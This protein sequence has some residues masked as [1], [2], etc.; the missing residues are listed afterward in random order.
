M[1]EVL[2]N[3]ELKISLPEGFREM[4]PDEMRQGFGDD[5]PD[6]LGVRDEERHIIFAVTWKVSNEAASKIASTKSL[7]E[8]AEKLIRKG[9]KKARIEYNCHGFFEKRLCGQEAWGFRYDY[10]VQGVGQTAETT[11]F[12]N[13]ISCYTLQYLSRTADAAANL[14]VY[15]GILNSMSIE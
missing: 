5:Y 1:G 15:E 8:R 4:T 11:V 13:G 2:I 6:R 9:Y 14:E 10:A 12:K 3:G 7:A